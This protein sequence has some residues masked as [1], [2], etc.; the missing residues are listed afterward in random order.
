MMQQA[1]ANLLDNAVKFSPPGS[2]VGWARRG[3]AGQAEIMV[4]DQG[5]GFRKTTAP[6][7]PS[8]SSAARC[9]RSTPG[10]GLGL[11]L[12]Q[13]VAQ[14]HGGMLLLEDDHP[15]LRARLVLPTSE[16]PPEM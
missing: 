5:P 4:A 8:G 7:R 13:A 9:A 15:G 2:K 14:L 11:A 10:S 3:R 6:A 1:V 12:V 16:S